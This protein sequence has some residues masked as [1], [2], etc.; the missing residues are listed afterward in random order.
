MK[1]NAEIER[2]R[3]KA[4]ATRE[5]YAPLLDNYNFEVLLAWAERKASA[6]GIIPPYQQR[7]LAL[8]AQ[9]LVR[10]FLVRRSQLSG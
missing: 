8:V 6:L 7:A 3:R 9:R 2:L 1:I 5:K 10:G 4:D